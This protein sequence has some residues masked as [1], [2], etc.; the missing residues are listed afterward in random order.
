MCAVIGALTQSSGSGK[1]NG[2]FGPELHII[3]RYFLSI[4]AIFF[5]FFF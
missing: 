4:D 5:L 3:V 2:S 1:Q